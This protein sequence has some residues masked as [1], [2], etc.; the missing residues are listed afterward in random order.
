M[1]KRSK[2]L[3]IIARYIKSCQVESQS[4]SVLELR[5][6]WCFGRG[7]LRCGH[8]RGNLERPSPHQGHPVPFPFVSSDCPTCSQDSW[9]HPESGQW[10]QWV[11]SFCSGSVPA[12]HY[13]SRVPT[14]E[15]ASLSSAVWTGDAGSVRCWKAW[16]VVASGWVVRPLLLYLESCKIFHTRFWFFS[17]GGRFFLSAP[18]LPLELR[19]G[20]TGRSLWLVFWGTLML[21]SEN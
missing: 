11:D 17:C 7:W 9:D 19:I 15:K 20:S 2:H 13:R 18:P 8:L 16:Q 14:G 10:D 3:K 21:L 12:V 1:W 4:L 6:G 5:V